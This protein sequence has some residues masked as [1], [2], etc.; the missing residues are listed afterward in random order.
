MLGYWAR[1]PPQHVTTGMLHPRRHY[2]ADG[3]K[4]VD[5]QPTTGMNTVRNE[6]SMWPAAHK[7][8][9]TL[10]EKGSRHTQE[11]H[12]THDGR[13][14]FEVEIEWALLPMDR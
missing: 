5:M 6:G 4:D 8:Q 11:H 9:V 12:A 10:P 2:G 1:T 13:T 7:P 14:K 3:Q